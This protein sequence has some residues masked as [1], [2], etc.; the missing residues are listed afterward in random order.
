MAVTKL[1]EKRDLNYECA[2]SKIYQ[3]AN[4]TSVLVV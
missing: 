2:I 1:R 3:K 4:P